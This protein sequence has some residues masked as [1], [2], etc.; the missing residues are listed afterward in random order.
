VRVRLAVAEVHLPNQTGQ[1]P[2]VAKSVGH[3]SLPPI[4]RNAVVDDSMAVRM[5][6]RQQRHPRRGANRVGAVSAFEANA[7][8]GDAVDA[9]SGDQVPAR[10]AHQVW[11][12]LV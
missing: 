9:W 8:F 5:Q 12:V 3:R 4:E 11:P 1:V 7:A 2:G 10:A 6:P